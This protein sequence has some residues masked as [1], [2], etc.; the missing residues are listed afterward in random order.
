VNGVSTETLQVS[1]DAERLL[2]A[3]GWQ[4]GLPSLT[5]YDPDGTDVT[6]SSA[7]D[8]AIST[9]AYSKL[10]GVQLKQPQPGDW[11]AE[12]GNLTGVE[13]YKFVYFASKG[14]P[15][16]AE[17]PGRFLTPAAGAHD[18]T[19]VY[20]VTWDVPPGTPVSATVSLYYTPYV[21]DPEL[22]FRPVGV[23]DVPIVKNLAFNTGRYV[24]DTTGLDTY[25]DIVGVPEGPFH[26]RLRAVVDDGVN[27]FPPG[28]A[29]DPRDPCE[30]RC[31]LPSE[32]AFDPNRFPGI[33]TFRSMGYVVVTDTVAPAA[34]KGLE[35]EGV[36]GAILA[37]W[38]PSPEKDV[39]A[40]VVRRGS[41]REFP[42]PGGWTRYVDQRVTAVLSPTLRLGGLTTGKRPYQVAVKA[43]DVNG[44]ESRFSS[45][46]SATPTG[47]DTDPVPR[48][49][50]SLTVTSQTSTDV[51]F[52]WSPAE[53]GA[54]PDS[55]RLVAQ[56]LVDFETIGG[57]TDTFEYVDTTAPFATV[58]SLRTG[59]TYRVS[60]SALNSDGWTSASSDPITVTVTDGV[61]DDGDG[62]P[63]DWAMAY[64]VYSAT[65]DA[66]DDGLQN[67]L[68]L[69]QGTDPTAQDTDGDGF[70][71][72]EE[73]AA[74]I[75]ALDR[76]SFPARM[77]QPRL[78]L[79]R[80][81]V[82]FRAKKGQPEPHAQSVRFR[83]TGGGHLTLSVESDSAW[84]E[85][86]LDDKPFI[87]DRVQVSVD[88]SG[89]QPGYHASV[90][91]V[92][93]AE[94]SDPIIGGP[95][96]IAVELWLSPADTD[97][98]SRAVYLPLV[99]RAA[100]GP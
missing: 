9:T 26:H 6:L 10:M 5:L 81:R 63:D 80:N 1:A 60:V 87:R 61:D 27:T 73:R 30:P 24:W 65:L 100:S 97:I 7:Y 71:D 52:E 92:H 57:Y 29:Y 18:G 56:W 83:N 28:A 13:H 19:G 42:W 90:V 66:D 45:I 25:C 31:E 95:H 4:A 32:R 88:T 39:A 22:G 89:L 37:R 69:S 33:S 12:I 78:E 64:G 14:A 82:V 91:R 38:D 48:A 54:V 44:N 11:H 96:C 47:A 79:E 67:A 23:E 99:L 53:T 51:G 46:E 40:Y 74:G 20:T 59:A 34:P 62:L 55:Y 77:T 2:V 72:R 93:P 17:D 3:L 94:G 21:D 8:V 41:Y 98:P 75:D 68:E 15:G 76:L 70:S 85:A 49:P 36:D 58:S 84:I 43:I 35:L 50:I 16:T 86:S